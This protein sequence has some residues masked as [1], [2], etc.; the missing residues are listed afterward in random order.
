MSVYAYKFDK[1]LT[2]DKDDEL[3]FIPGADGTWVAKVVRGGV[4]IDETVGRSHDIPV[5][6]CE[7]GEFTAWPN[8]GHPATIAACPTNLPENK[9]EQY[10]LTDAEQTE[11]GREMVGAALE[12][13]GAKSGFDFDDAQDMPALILKAIVAA[14]A[15]KEDRLLQLKQRHGAQWTHAWAEVTQTVAT[16]FW[17]W[18]EG[19]SFDPEIHHNSRAGACFVAFARAIMAS[20]AVSMA[21]G[22]TNDEDDVI[23][24]ADGAKHLLKVL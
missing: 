17:L 23:G 10:E 14:E 15:V 20:T 1:P 21:I 6:Q 16:A 5:V 19:R 4:V 7:L 11:I 12:A 13:L 3:Y 18:C 8:Q 24:A 9:M 2:F 22:V